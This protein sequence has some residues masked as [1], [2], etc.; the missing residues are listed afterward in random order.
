MAN[1]L[2]PYFLTEI[3][4]NIR[5]DINQ[6]RGAQLLTGGMDMKTEL[7]LTIEYDMTFDDTGMTPATGLNDPTPVRAKQQVQHMS[8]TNQEWREKKI[9]DREKIAK[10]RAPGTSLE[11]MWAEEYMVESMIELNQRLETRIEWMRW[12]AL[13]GS[14]V[15]PATS[16]KPQQTLNY[17]VPGGQ[18]PTASTLWS[19]IATANPLQDIDNWKLIFRGTGARASKIIVNQKVDNYL[20]QNANIQNLLRTV[21]GRDVMA[22]DS[23]AF[24]MKNQ[25]NGLDYEVYDAG[26]LDDTGT[27]NPFIPDNACVI[28]GEGMTGNLMDMVTSPNNYEDIFNGVPGKFAL[29]KKVHGDPEQ[30]AAI[31]GV[32]ALPRLKHANWH[33]FATVA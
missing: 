17:G 25:L 2:D 15:I 14:I 1:V 13:K 8:F 26:Y 24:V 32:T 19:T 23:L 33:V 12:Q 28:V 20:K 31:N 6:F 16:S 27:F 21:Y 29:T 9:I 11:Q 5:V 10:L 22:A 7:G 4:R 3:V 18:L 30:W